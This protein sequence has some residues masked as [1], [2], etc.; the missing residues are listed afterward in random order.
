MTMNDIK[1]DLRQKRAVVVCHK[2]TSDE[3]AL[4]KMC[5]RDEEP[6]PS[7]AACWRIRYLVYTFLVLPS[8]FLSDAFL[9]DYI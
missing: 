7:A 9:F 3:G 2:S 1:E 8:T 5:A 6:W 4:T